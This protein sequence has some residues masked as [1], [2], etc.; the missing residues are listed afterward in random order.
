MNLKTSRRL[1]MGDTLF[2]QN[3]LR[4]GSQP[5]ILPDKVQSS[6]KNNKHVKLKIVFRDPKFS[7]KGLY[8]L[9]FYRTDKVDKIFDILLDKTDE[10]TAD[11][12]EGQNVQKQFQN[13]MNEI[14][15]LKKMVNQLINKMNK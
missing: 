4:H 11:Q 6:L 15:G 13:I 3:F 12:R 8:K 14:A 7:D 2:I 1:K 9:Y 10:P 5:C